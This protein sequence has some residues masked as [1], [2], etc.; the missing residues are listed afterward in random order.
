MQPGAARDHLLEAA[1][2]TTRSGVRERRVHRRAGV[3]NY[4]HVPDEAV[5]EG[6]VVEQVQ[7]RDVD[8]RLGERPR[9]PDARLRLHV[10]AAEVE[11]ERVGGLG[12]PE[13]DLDRSPLGVERVLVHVVGEL[14]RTVLHRRELLEQDRLSVVEHQGKHH[15]DRLDAVPLDELADLG[16]SVEAPHLR[17]DVSVGLIGQPH[18]RE[19]HARDITPVHAAVDDLDRCDP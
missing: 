7:E 10:G 14:N 12:E 1:G 16:L 15:Q 9:A 6:D 4:P 18:V 17:P 11:R 13:I 19:D 5:V 8:T 2:G 3:S